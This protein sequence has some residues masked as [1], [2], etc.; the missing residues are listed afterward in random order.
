M[1][2]QCVFTVNEAPVFANYCMTTVISKTEEQN[3]FAV[4]QLK[5]QLS[6]RDN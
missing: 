6:R 2:I 1:K 3:M 5:A 4:V